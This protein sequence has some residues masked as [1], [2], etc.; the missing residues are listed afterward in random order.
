MCPANDALPEGPSRT[1][2]LDWKNWMELSS[3]VLANEQCLDLIGWINVRE[4]D[5]AFT[6]GKK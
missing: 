5:P 6:V 2:Q 4:W 1:F 3:A